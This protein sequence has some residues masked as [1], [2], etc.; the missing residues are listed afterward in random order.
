MEGHLVEAAALK[1]ALL[2][3]GTALTTAAQQ[4]AATEDAVADAIPAVA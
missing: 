3:Q 1:D 4:F 2:A